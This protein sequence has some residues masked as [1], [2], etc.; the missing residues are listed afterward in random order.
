MSTGMY[1][2]L[3]LLGAVSLALWVHVRAERFA[4]EKMRDCLIHMGVALVACRILAP[5]ASGLLTGTGRAELRFVAVIGVSLPAL[6][7]TLLTFVWVVL[8][9]Q[10]T[11]R[12]GTLD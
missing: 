9:M 8:L 11:M 12:R 7:Y 3:F 10:G 6:T 5:I 2:A 1:A 4:P